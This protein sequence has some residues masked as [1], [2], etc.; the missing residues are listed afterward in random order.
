[1]EDAYIKETTQTEIRFTNKPL[2][3]GTY[4]TKVDLEPL[5]F[6]GRSEYVLVNVIAHR[7]LQDL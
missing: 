3:K 1:M 5:A 4:G 7:Y 6:E 2:A